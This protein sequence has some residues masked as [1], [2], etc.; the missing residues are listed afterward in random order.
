MANLL[1]PRCHDYGALPSASQ[2]SGDWCG[3]GRRLDSTGLRVIQIIS[4]ESKSRY[5]RSYDNIKAWNLVPARQMRKFKGKLTESE[6]VLKSVIR[7]RGLV[8]W[9]KIHGISERV[10]EAGHREGGMCSGL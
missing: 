5:M 4:D 9:E 1:K 8:V 6:K 2:H 7:E 10:R 3:I